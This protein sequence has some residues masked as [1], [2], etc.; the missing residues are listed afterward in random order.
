MSWTY[1]QL[2]AADA[3][4]VPTQSDPAQAAIVLN[5]QTIILNNQP[6]AWPAAK[7]IAR[8][9]STGDWARIVARARQI[10]TL[11]PMTATDAAILA[12]INAIESEDTDIIDPA[13]TAE[14]TAFQT[15]LNALQAT[16]DI[17][18]ATIS[19]ISA[20]TTSIVPAWIPAVT[21]G[22]VQ[23]ARGQ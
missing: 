23:T 6:V 21:A 5:A 1:A 16:G 22:D 3:A 12:A 10:P 4:L 20:L 7:R 2:Q 9:S 19:A 11:P 17:S 8:T 15:G 18:V 14:W 13:N